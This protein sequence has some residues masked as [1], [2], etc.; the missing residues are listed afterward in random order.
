MP[1]R[2]II[3]RVATL[4]GLSALAVVSGLVGAALTTRFGT[5]N[6]RISYI[7]FISVILTALGVILTA[8]TLFV[9]ALA[10]I[11]WTSIETRLRSHSIEF[12]G[13]ELREDKP[14]GRMVRKAVRDAVYEGVMPADSGEHEDVPIA[15]DDCEADEPQP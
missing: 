2:T 14:L 3:Q 1:T 8:V 6:I 5:S 11:G 15:A 4:A 10:V 13:S 12:I 9:G 7:D